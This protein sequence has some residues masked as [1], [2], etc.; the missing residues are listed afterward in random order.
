MATKNDI[1]GDSLTSK[2]P[3]KAYDK[4]WDRIFKKESDLESNSEFAH[5]AYTRYPHL[6]EKDFKAIQQD[7]TELNGDGNRDRGRYGEDLSSEK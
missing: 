2:S 5:P 1:T 4:G 6:K 7:H 3:T